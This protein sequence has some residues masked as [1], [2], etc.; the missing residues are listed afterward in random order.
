MQLVTRLLW[1]Q[2][3]IGS[4]PV[5]PTNLKGREMERKSDVFEWL[6]AANIREL[7]KK[8]NELKIKK[9]DVVS[10]IYNEQYILVYCK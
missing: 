4:S 7:T 3:T 8:M 9:E 5:I 2:E 1:E 6:V 10:L